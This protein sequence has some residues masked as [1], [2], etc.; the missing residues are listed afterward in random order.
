M[1]RIERTKGFPSD[2]AGNGGIRSERAVAI[3][4]ERPPMDKTHWMRVMR[5]GQLTRDPELRT[6]REIA[7]DRR[8]AEALEA[9]RKA[10]F[11]GESPDRVNIATR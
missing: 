1:N 10:L 4:P 6:R 3:T 8:R 2:D 5:E 7:E 11:A 9:R